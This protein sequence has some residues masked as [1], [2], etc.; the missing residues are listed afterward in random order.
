MKT[1]TD[2]ALQPVRHKEE[3]WRFVLRLLDGLD[4]R[5]ARGRYRDRLERSAR[6]SPRSHLG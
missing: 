6:Q 5:L 3:G 2:A 1:P 4:A